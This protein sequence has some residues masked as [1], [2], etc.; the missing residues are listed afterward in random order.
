MEIRY[1]ALI[2]IVVILTVGLIAA[3]LNPD[4]WSEIL[5]FTGPTIT[6]LIVL[7]KVQD[8]HMVVNSRMDELLNVT[9]SAAKA[10]GVIEGKAQ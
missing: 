3:T 7:V 9:R 10:E 6:A 8:Y 1:V 5:Q 4:R 2:S